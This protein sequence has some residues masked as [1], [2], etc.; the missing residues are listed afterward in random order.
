MSAEG[1]ATQPKP[2]GEHNRG[3][4]AAV[5]VPGYRLREPMPD[6]HAG[7][8]FLAEP[9][10]GGEPVVVRVYGVGRRTRG[11]EAPGVQAGVLRL[12]AGLVPAPRVLEWRAA[13]SAGPGL[14]VMTRLP[15]VPLVTVLPR[16]DGVLQR[17]LGASMGEILGRLSGLALPGIGAFTDERLTRGM[18]PLH[19]ESLVGWLDHHRTG[20]VLEELGAPALESLTRVA[21][22]AERLLAV[23]P[24][25]CLVHGDL[26]ARNVLCDPEAGAITGLVDWEFAHPGHPVEDLGKL[27][28]KGPGLPF[29]DAT[30]E[31]MTPWLPA[32]ER[33]DADA[34]RERG[35][36]ADL[37]WLIEMASR[38]GQSPAT[39]R[40]FRLIEVIAATGDL[41]GDLTLGGTD[42]VSV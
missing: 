27:L 6:G 40:A 30:I 8:V 33:A 36:A 41:L 42:R 39:Y 34:V 10:E 32:A 2:G 9:E 7:E 11:P 5:S 26:S 24:R 1:A 20:T 16:A 14:L 4:S 37:Y 21:E 12:V 25:A 28:R 18:Y 31:A 22:H 23:S 19:S 17:R 15:G 38:R 13:D 29:V 3:M 35:R